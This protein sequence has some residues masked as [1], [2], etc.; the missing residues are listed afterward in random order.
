MAASKEVEDILSMAGFSWLNTRAWNRVF[1]TY[2]MMASAPP[3]QRKNYKGQRE[4]DQEPCGDTEE[5]SK[6]PYR[7]W[8]AV[9]SAIAGVDNDRN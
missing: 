6:M 8:N 4:D 3:T 5:L 2:P 7:R 9:I 1:E